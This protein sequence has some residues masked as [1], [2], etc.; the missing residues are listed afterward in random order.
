M[1]QLLA[2][3]ISTHTWSAHVLLQ[4]LNTYCHLSRMARTCKDF[5][6]FIHYRLGENELYYP[7]LR[8]LCILPCV[9]HTRK[10]PCFNG[11]R[12]GP[13][14]VKRSNQEICL[15]L[16]GLQITARWLCTA[17]RC[18]LLEDLGVSWEEVGSKNDFNTSR[19]RSSFRTRCLPKSCWVLLWQ[20]SAWKGTWPQLPRPDKANFHKP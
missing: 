11:L 1:S 20:L 5:G 12:E 10:I 7:L 17:A 4:L 16:E 13:V 19:R 2:S 15:P 14:L 18:A 9:K 8:N 6:E 3:Y